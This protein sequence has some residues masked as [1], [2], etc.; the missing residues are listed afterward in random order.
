MGPK[1]SGLASQMKV[2]PA[3]QLVAT[4]SGTLAGSV[5]EE[6][7]ILAI[8]VTHECH[9]CAARHDTGSVDM[10]GVV[11]L[12]QE[13]QTLVG[14]SPNQEIHGIVFIAKQEKVFEVHNIP[15]VHRRAKESDLRELS[16]TPLLNVD[17]GACSNYQPI[18]SFR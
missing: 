11:I 17:I 16:S 14:L 6:L 5:L 8:V 3:D 9:R 1:S 15:H 4:A 2:C 10:N 12:S 7:Q 13:R 18:L